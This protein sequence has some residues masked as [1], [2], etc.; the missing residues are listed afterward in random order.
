MLI[1]TINNWVGGF[2]FI[3]IIIL[4][5][6]FGILINIVIHATARNKE[7]RFKNR[8]SQVALKHLSMMVKVI[9]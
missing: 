5:V 7:N 1:I 4:F 3:I 2:Y 6:L 9:N 8:K